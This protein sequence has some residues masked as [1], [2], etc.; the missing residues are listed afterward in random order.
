[1][2][3]DR[4][5]G[6]DLLRFLQDLPDPRGKKG[7]RHPLG[8]MLRTV[9]SSMLQG[10]TSFRG[11]G[12]WLRTQTVTT[13]HAL[14]YFRK[15]PQERAFRV[16]L[17]RLDPVRLEAALS[18]WARSRED[19]FPLGDDPCDRA[20]ALDGK[21]VRGSY[22]DEHSALHLLALYS[23][24]LKCATYQTKKPPETNEEKAAVEWIDTA[25]RPN[26]VIT[27]DAAFCYREICTAVQD[28]GADYFIVVKDNQPTL[29]ETLAD[30][31]SPAFSPLQRAPAIDAT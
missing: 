13:W 2:E 25:V 20:E 19:A 16:L 11:I 28:A 17:A 14:G 30:D 6:P 24:R 3:P 26:S 10:A 18:A 27:A 4:I 29:K 23:H 15:P 31:F 5:C 8:A 1:M 12:Q 9:V 21:V 22:G 7:K